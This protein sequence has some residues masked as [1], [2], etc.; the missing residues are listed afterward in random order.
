MTWPGVEG[1]S[2]FLERSADLSATPRF[3]RVG[4]NLVGLTGTNTF[5][6]R[7]A[8]GLPALF[9]RVGVRE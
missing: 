2:Y 5:T 4:T 7:N 8:V 3:T 9:Y 6:D 1:V